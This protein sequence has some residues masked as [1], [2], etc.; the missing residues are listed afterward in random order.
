MR[1]LSL[2]ERQRK[3][4][5]AKNV[6]ENRTRPTSTPESIF[7]IPNECNVFSSGLVHA[8]VTREFYSSTNPTYTFMYQDVEGKSEKIPIMYAKKQGKAI[9]IWDAQK[10]PPGSFDLYE[11]RENLSQKSGNY[12]GKLKKNAGKKYNSFSLYCSKEKKEQFGAFLFENTS[13]KEQFRDGIPPRKVKVAIPTVSKCG[14]MERLPMYL[15][16]KMVENVARKVSTGM[17]VFTSRDPKYDRGQYRLNFNGR[18]TVASVKNFQLVQE[19]NDELIAQ[20]GKNGDHRFHLDYKEPFNAFQA[21]A[22]ALSALE[23]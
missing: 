6:I 1:L 8:L 7:K 9:R 17:N 19:S 12:C 4:E 22:L 2:E 13:L 16:N 14:E 23:L 18:V 5:N 20:F 21:F 3:L 15:R 11:L 10:I